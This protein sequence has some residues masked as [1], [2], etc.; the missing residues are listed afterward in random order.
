M[1]LVFNVI[2]RYFVIKYWDSFKFELKKRVKKMTVVSLR[3]ITP[4]VGKEKLVESRMRVRGI[5][6]EHGTHEWYKTVV[7]Q[8]IGNYLQFSMYESFSTATKYF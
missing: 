5:I 4:H 6:A 3:E 8:G 1:E 7:G 2:V